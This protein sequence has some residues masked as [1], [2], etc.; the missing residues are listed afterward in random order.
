[1]SAAPRILFVEN[2]PELITRME[3]WLAAH[4]YRVRKAI[5]RATG[6]QKTPA[7]PLDLAV[8]SKS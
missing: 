7:D 6:L 5:D 2:K 1:M 3:L 8:P 4:R